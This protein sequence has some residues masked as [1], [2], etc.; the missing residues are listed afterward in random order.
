[1]TIPHPR[2]A[3]RLLIATGALGLLTLLYVPIWRIDL[4]APQYP[5]GL[6]LQIFHDRFTGDVNKING[7][8]HYIGMA[9][10]HNEMFPEFTIMRYAFY[11]LAGWGLIAA[12]IGRRGA[13]FSWIMALFAFVIWAMWDMFAWGYKYGHDLDPHAAIKVEGMA[14]QPPLLGH[15]KLLN[16]DAW[17]LPDTG[18]WI[19]FTVITTACLVWFIEWRWPKQAHDRRQP[20]TLGARAPVLALLLFALI[21]HACNRS[22]VPEV[23]IGKA[24][25]GHCRMNVMDPH[26]ASA[27]VTAGGRTYAFD[28]PECMVQYVAGG[29]IAEHQVRGWW[30]CDHAHAGTFIDATKAYYLRSAALKSPMNG[31][32]AAFAN[33][34]DRAA[35]MVEKGGETL[36]WGRARALLT[37]H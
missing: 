23:A 6:A 21:H 19:L 22:G 7:L 27:I 16:F 32:T 8:N 34:A 15:K 35:A 31:N 28:S 36:D 17:S 18:G 24:E 9:T 4:A 30:V 33:E 11:L 14:Y 20:S 5:E 1:M 37:D 13:F 29:S 2:R 12:L 25:C 10:I 3:S 26:F